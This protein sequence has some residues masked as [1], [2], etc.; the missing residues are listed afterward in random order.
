MKRKGMI[1]FALAS[2]LAFSAAFTSLAAEGWAQADNNWVYYTSSGSKVTNEWRKGAD[3]LWRYLDSSGNM[4]INKWIE[5]IYYVDSNGILVTEKWLKLPKSSSSDEYIWYY[6]GSSGK[7]ITENWKKIDDKWYYFDTDGEM[8]T[9]W[10]LDDMYY[11]GSDGVMRTGWQRLDP[12]DKRDDDENRVTPGS[13]TSTEDDGKEWYYFSPNGKK[14]VPDLD[15]ADYEAHKIEGVYYC[16]DEEGAMQTGWKNVKTSD[17]HD[18]SIGDY[19]YFDANGKIVT[20]WLSLEPPEQIAGQYDHS[21]EWFYFN[22]NGTPEYGKAEGE[23]TSSD[24]KKINGVTY[25]FDERGTPVY[26]LHRIKTGSDSYT[27]YY[28]GDRATSSL[29]KGKVNID[30]GTGTTCQYYFSESGRGYS[31]VRDN[32]LYYM[33]KLQKAD[34]KT[35]YQAISIPNGNSYNTYVVNTSGKVAKSTTVKDSDGVKYKTSSNGLLTYVD[36]EKAENGMYREPEEPAWF[37]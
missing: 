7:K 26:G 21:V 25:L 10:I 22:S 5:D 18:S 34:S 27:A 28:F 8:L 2:L 9:G 4:A 37:E 3:N 17:D 1:I 24:F 29:V 20:G 11:T 32:Y 6:F 13:N 23:S 33:G 31:G 30:E 36:D 35:K 14:Y 12:P 16:F 19:K 15:D